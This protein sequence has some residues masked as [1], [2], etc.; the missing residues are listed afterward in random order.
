MRIQCKCGQGCNYEAST[1]EAT[2]KLACNNSRMTSYNIITYKI[3]SEDK[4]HDNKKESYIK[5]F[6]DYS[7]AYNWIVNTLDCSKAWT[8][9]KV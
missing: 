6:K 5:R 9:D 7:E 2:N 8:I 1:Y 3:Y 4:P